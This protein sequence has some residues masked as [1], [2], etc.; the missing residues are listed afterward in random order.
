MQALCQQGHSVTC[1]VREYSKKK[2]L[3]QSVAQEPV[4]GDRLKIVEVEWTKPGS[5]LRYVA[6][7]EVVINTVGIIRERHHGDFEAVHTR[8]PI[9]LFQQAAESGASKIVQISAMGADEMAVSKFHASKREADR[10]LSQLN[11]PHVIIRPSFVY[12]GGGSSM[13]FF[14]HLVALPVT[15]IP[16]DGQYHVQPIHIDDLVKA[17]TISLYRDDLRSITVDAGGGEILTFDQMLEILGHQIGKPVRYLHIPWNM[18]GLVAKVTDLIGGHGPI[19]E[20]EASMLKRDNFLDNKKFVE[21]F[22]FEPLTFSEGIAQPG[23][24]ERT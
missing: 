1:L 12:G 20:E 7:H 21:S 14:A 13:D 2:L 6:G 17:I 16:G 4:T 24:M 18:I 10:Y 3:A 19:T 15:P 11:V 22:G 9:A 5:W 23:T 8:A